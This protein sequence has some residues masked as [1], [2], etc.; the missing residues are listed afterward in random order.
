MR[1]MICF[2]LGLLLGFSSFAQSFE[3]FCASVDEEGNVSISFQPQTNPEFLEYRILT[4][5][6]AAS[7]YVNHDVIS[8]ETQSVYTD[9]TQQATLGVVRYRI[10]A[11]F[12][13]GQILQ[14]EIETIFLAVVPN[15]NNTVNLFWNEVRD[16][17]NDEE[18]SHRYNVYRKRKSTDTDWNL[19]GMSSE[20][21]YVDTLPQIC[22]DT[23]CYVVELEDESGCLNRSN[24]PQ[25]LVGDTEI[26]NSPILQSATVNLDSQILNLEWIP[27]DSDDVFGYVVCGGSPCIAIDT[28]WG[29]DASHYECDDCDIEQLNSLAVM[30]F[31]SCFNT[32]LRTETHTNMVLI[33]NSVHCSDKI[34]LA[35]NH[36]DNFETGLQHYNIYSRKA[37]STAFNLEGTTQNNNAEIQIDITENRYSFYVEAISNDGI[38]AKS[39][40]VEID[41]TAARQV[42]FIEIRKVSV[43]ENNTDIDLEFYVDA[44]LPVNFYRLERAVDGG[45]YSLVAN[46]PYTGNNTLTH[47]DRLPTSAVEHSYRYIL[48]APDECGLSFKQSESV[49]PMQMTLKNTDPTTNMLSWTPYSGW[50]NGVGFYEIYRYS[51]GETVPFQVAVTSDNTYTDY[52]EENLSS[53]DRTFYFVK[54]NEDGLGR[55]NKTQSA[56]STFAY[57]IHETKIFIPNAITPNEPDN[58]VFK[59]QCHFI[60]QGSYRMSIFDRYGAL[61][62]MTEDLNEGWNGSFKGEYCKQGVYIYMIEFVNSLGEKETRKGTIALIE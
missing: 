48:S 3:I 43:R 24:Q 10:Q 22:S 36:Y 2:L 6:N 59:P 30:A 47:T 27:S 28:I 17:N 12:S 23:I 44:S 19:V 8:D 11:V 32:S 21:T 45:A 57:V 38:M 9:G 55:D 41:L 31:D 51:Q 40:M 37:S 34:S 54:A 46:L 56:N 61:I 39:N 14:D 29:A 58:N 35:W 52:L 53:S 15:Q 42:E 50:E 20:N 1:R 26:P 33:C 18:M 7:D 62:F 4:W 16:A 5:D 49:S 13:S 25:I 60:Q